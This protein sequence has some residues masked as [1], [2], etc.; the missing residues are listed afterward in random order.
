[1]KTTVTKGEFVT[2]L[3]TYYPDSFSRSG[4]EALFDYLEELEEGTGQEM[5][6]DPIALCC[7]YSEHDSAKEA[8]EEYGYDPDI[9]PDN[10]D[11]DPEAEAYE[12]LNS[13]TVIIQF[14]GGVI[15]RDF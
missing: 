13:N 10:L 15:I 1:M 11:A 2:R 9:D 7:E 4:L 6:F 14:D 12:Y 3:M 8:A 5:E